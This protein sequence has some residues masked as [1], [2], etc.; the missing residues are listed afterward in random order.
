LPFVK[1]WISAKAAI[2]I[3]F[4]TCPTNPTETYD[5]IVCF[6]QHFGID[7]IDHLAET[8]SVFGIFDFLNIGRISIGNTS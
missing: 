6:C 7:L 4:L 3:N 1:L 5:H 8:E 2:Q